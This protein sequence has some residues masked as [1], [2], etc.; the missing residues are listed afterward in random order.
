MTMVQW[1]FILA[2]ALLLL[3]GFRLIAA[4]LLVIGYA[5]AFINGQIDVYALPFFVLLIG[6]A[7]C[8]SPRRRLPVQIAGHV[9]FVLLAAA[10][11]VH[12]VPGFHN[13]RVID[14]TNFTPDAISYS[15]YLNLDKP[16]IAYWLVLVS[17]YLELSTP[18]SGWPKV[19]LAAIVTILVC[20]GVAFLM[21][22]MTWEPKWP[23]SGWIW[24]VNNLL[25]VAFPEEALFRGY[26]LAGLNRQFSRWPFGQWLAILIA[27]VLFG[28]AHFQSGGAMIVLATIAG[29][30][31]GAAYRWG[32]LQG[33]VMT[34][35]ALNLTHFSL[36]TYPALMR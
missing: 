33:S 7:A 4:G 34:H 29:I 1:G 23:A 26:I 13:P 19:A 22:F 18:K 12:W 25:L 35:L 15:M 6:A 11:F 8:I 30:G 2:G 36:F 21:R 31:Y 28:L 5:L 20:I 3:G 14:P 17:P 10:L 24:V 16:L 9:V 32:G 27:A